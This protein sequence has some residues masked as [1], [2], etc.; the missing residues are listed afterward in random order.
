MGK[1]L[2]VLIVEDSEDD[3]LLLLRHL[4]RAGYE[5]MFE[6][7]E[8]SEAMAAALEQQTWDVVIADHDLPHFSVP[9]ALSVLKESGQDLPFLIVSGTMGED[10]AIA[11]MHAGAH[12]YLM[13][14]NLAR[15]APAIE[16]ELREAENRRE[17]GRA[18]EAIHFQAHLL[19][20][21]EQ[22]IIATDLDGTITY[23]NRFAETL[24]GWSAQEMIG[25]HVLELATPETSAKAAEVLT[26]VRAGESWTGELWMR[27]RDGAAFPA[28]VTATPIYDAGGALV[29]IVSVS[30][31]ITERK[32]AEEE[33]AQLLHREQA[34]RAEADQAVRLREEF[35]SIA[36]HELKT[37]LTT[38]KGYV[39]LL[40]REISRPQLD[41][42]LLVELLND[43]QAQ[44]DRFETLVNDLLDA[45]RIQQGRLE[46]RPE[47]LDLTA[48]AQQVLERFEHAAERTERHTLVLEAPGP[49][50]GTWDP[51][52]LD[53]VLTNLVSNALKYSPEGGEVRLRLRHRGDSVEVM[54]SDQGVG[55]PPEEQALL[56]QPFVRGAA[57]RNIG[58][59]GLGLYI[60]AQIVARHGGSI[61]IQSE[62]GVGSTF[63]V[64]LPLAPSMV[65]RPL[66]SV[67]SGEEAND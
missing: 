31:D 5:V 4:S 32:R 30:T 27:R 50:W 54:V 35:L 36:S 67:V 7:V 15:L 1:P 29:G 18:E 66:S 43:L 23:W 6:R 34:A 3:T 62:V 24:Y 14:D 63:T 17:R 42:D 61:H 45:S 47:P 64:C 41:H 8:T 49:I 11:A 39:Q 51:A 22:A 25:R 44:V 28:L 40:S 9:A 58:G 57:G 46:L 26:D 56:F 53:Q 52:Q 48:L 21:V 37:P 55:I 60:T 33:L 10:V 19:N 12:D 20:T 16:R 59:T 2:R 13:K 38:V 65:V